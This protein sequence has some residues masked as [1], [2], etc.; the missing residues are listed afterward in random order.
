VLPRRLRRLAISPRFR[1]QPARRRLKAALD[2]EA[3][4]QAP[5]RAV[6]SD[7]APW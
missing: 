5:R 7:E 2:A 3:V 4:E 1:A 6:G